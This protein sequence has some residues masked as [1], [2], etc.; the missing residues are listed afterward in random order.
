MDKND[1]I[2]KMHDKNGECTSIVLQSKMYSR[3]QLHYSWARSANFSSYTAKPPSQIV[4]PTFRS[5]PQSQQSLQIFP[6]CVLPTK[7][8]R[9]HCTEL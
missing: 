6:G 1:R 5:K 9:C 3:I 8:N 2:C 7:C 4:E